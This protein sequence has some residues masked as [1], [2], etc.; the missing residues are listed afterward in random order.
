ME[1]LLNIARGTEDGSVAK[2]DEAAVLA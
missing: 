1:E 2:R